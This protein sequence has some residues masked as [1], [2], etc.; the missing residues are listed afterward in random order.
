MH[1]TQCLKFSCGTCAAD[2]LHSKPLPELLHIPL[3]VKANAPECCTL[4]MFY[5]LVVSYH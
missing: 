3:Q 5:A 2:L 4:M 1:L